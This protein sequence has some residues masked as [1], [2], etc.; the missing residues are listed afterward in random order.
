MAVCVLA[1]SNNI[2]N[3]PLPKRMKLKPSK[4]AAWSDLETSCASTLEP[5][6]HEFCLKQ[7][8]SCECIELC[9]VVS[10][11]S[12]INLRHVEHPC[13]N[14]CLLTLAVVIVWAAQ[15][16][17][18]AVVPDICMLTTICVTKKKSGVSGTSGQGSLVKLRA[19]YSLTLCMHFCRCLIPTSGCCTLG[20]P[21]LRRS[22]WPR[23]TTLPG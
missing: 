23:A 1:G 19:E 2:Q 3:K 7:Q 20:M 10:G 15:T 4:P 14:S 11:H 16:G 13:M 21:S 9:T 6:T 22:P 5:C 17:L 12:D 8:Q 18:A